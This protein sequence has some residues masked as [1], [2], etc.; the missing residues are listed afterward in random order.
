MG[1]SQFQ[2][3]NPVL[4]NLQFNINDTY[5]AKKKNVDINVQ[6]SIS[7][8]MAGRNEANVELTIEIGEQSEEMPFYISATEGAGF[9][10]EQEAFSDEKEVEKLLEINAPALLLSY[11]RPIISNITSASQYPTY[12][13]P[14][15]NFN[16]LKH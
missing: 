15:V 7:K 14:F 13:I 11:L 1:T 9:R 3:T 4:K 2:F 16:N 8:K 10:W 5:V 12:N 6:I